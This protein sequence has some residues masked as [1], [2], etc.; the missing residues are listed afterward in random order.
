MLALLWIFVLKKL[1]DL[2][3]VFSQQLSLQVDLRIAENLY[4]H[5]LYPGFLN[6]TLYIEYHFS[7]TSEQTEKR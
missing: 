4:C 5:L 1:I 7:Y 2:S 3:E 6:K